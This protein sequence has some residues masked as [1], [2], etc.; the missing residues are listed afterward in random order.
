M[1]FLGIVAAGSTG[2]GASDHGDISARALTDQATNADTGQPTEDG[3]DAAVMVG[4]HLRGHDL[5]DLPAADLH[6]TWPAT[7]RIDCCAGAKQQAEQ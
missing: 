6:F 1:L 3:A 2:K 7:P 5:L 4:L